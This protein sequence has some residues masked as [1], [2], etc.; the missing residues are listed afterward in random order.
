M[1][2]AQ[3][4]TLFLATLTVLG[5]LSIL[6]YVFLLTGKR[7]SH[8]LYNLYNSVSVFLSQNMLLFS[9]IVSLTA[10]FGSLFYSEIALYEPCRLCWFQRVF[11]YPQVILFG[12]ALW[13]KTTDVIKYGIPLSI[14]GGFIAAYHYFI[15]I[16]GLAQPTVSDA[17]SIT[18]VSCVSTQFLTFGYVTIPLMAFTAFA[19]IILLCYNQKT[20]HKTYKLSI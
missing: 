19:M 20:L 15:Q 10:T 9:F 13:K 7:F 3:L 14:I 12:V 5:Q 1:D 8:A 18:G 6:A 16:Q 11:M 17:C 4:V 2:I